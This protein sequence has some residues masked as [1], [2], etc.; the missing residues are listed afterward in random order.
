MKSTKL[1]FVRHGQTEWNVQEKWQGHQDSPLTEM[2]CQ[3]AM[4][5]GKRLQNKTFTHLYS[6][7]LGRAYQTATAIAEVT[8]HTIVTESFLREKNLGIFEGLTSE[9]LV[10]RYPEEY[11]QFRT[12]DPDYA[13]PQGESIRQFYDRSVK[14]FEALA[15]RHPQQTIVVVTHGGI[16][17]NL[18]RYIFDLP[19]AIPRRVVIEN[20]SLNTV[21]YHEGQWKLHTWGDIAHLE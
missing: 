21:S 13:L 7:D 12:L 19:F 20:T 10:E 16:L 8:G 15:T 9:T 17:G 18:F 3:Q 6:S 1:I 5:V 4:A 2:G 14:G 11:E